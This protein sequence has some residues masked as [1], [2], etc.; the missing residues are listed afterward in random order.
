MNPVE[1]WFCSG[2]IRGGDYL[3]FDMYRNAQ[4]TPLLVAVHVRSERAWVNIP[5]CARCWF[6]HGVE[7]VTRWVFL[8]SALVTGLPTVLMAG[9]YLGGD[10]WA[11]SWQ[12]VFPWI[13][14]LA[15]L[16]LWLGVRQHRLPW[17]F[18]APRPE[19]HAREHPAVAALAEEGWKPGGPLG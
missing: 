15:W 14:T 6:G 2:P 3:R 1:C 7:R 12:I 9:S 18:L 8:G 4:Y 19:R 16:G 10:P 11:D 5:R 17:R 13:W